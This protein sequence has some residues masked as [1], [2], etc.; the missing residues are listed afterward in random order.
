MGDAFQ[1]LR[2]RE[3]LSLREDF[4]GTAVFSL[5]WV[6]S[7]PQRRAVG[8]DLD[9]PTL[10]WALTR[11]IRPAAEADGSGE[12]YDGRL[13]LRE[14][15]VLEPESEPVDILVAFNFSYW[16]FLSRAELRTYF[17]AAR[18]GLREDGIMFLDA[19][20]GAEVA[21]SKLEARTIENEDLEVN[22]GE[23]FVYLWEQYRYEPTSAR[24]D[25]AIH[26]EFEDGSRI[27]EAFYYVWRLWTLAELRDLL[28]EVG[29]SR[30]Q[31]WAEEEDED[32]EG[33]GCYQSI[34]T[35]DHQGVWWVYIS[36]EN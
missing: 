10:D 34:E 35:L 29:F 23:P 33:K 36:A 26:F 18:A 20:G 21:G 1:R 16:C 17:E 12:S 28:E 25:C 3:G 31:F 11:R 5:A 2:G 30:V 27:D 14:A 24:M 8:V 19:Y 7:D 9:G 6:R 32:G 15:N 4:C 13:S 22:S